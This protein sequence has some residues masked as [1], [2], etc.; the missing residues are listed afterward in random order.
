M[1]III[2]WLIPS[3]FFFSGTWLQAANTYESRV[4]AVLAGLQKDYAK[5][6]EESGRIHIKRIQKPEMDQFIRA[7]HLGQHIAIT[8]EDMISLVQECALLWRGTRGSL[9][10]IATRSTMADLWGTRLWNVFLQEKEKGTTDMTPSAF[11]YDP[12]RNATVSTGHDLINTSCSLLIPVG[13]G[14]A[15]QI[16]GHSRI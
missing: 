4:T 6:T 14:M 5:K 16:D 8:G 3:L 11:W 13:H 10:P 1:R 2:R 12:I 7:S 9:L 15:F